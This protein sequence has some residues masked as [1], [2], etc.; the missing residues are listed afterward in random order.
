M[1]L[2]SAARAVTV[3]QAGRRP[4]RRRG[5]RRTRSLQGFRASVTVELAVGILNGKR[6]CRRDRAAVPVPAANHE[7]ESLGPSSSRQGPRRPGGCHCQ[8]AHESAA[9]ATVG[10]R[11][12][13]G[14]TVPRARPGTARRSDSVTGSSVPGPGLHCDGAAAAPAGRGRAPWHWQPSQPG[15]PE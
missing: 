5:V 11:G 6:D 9:S 14:A 10:H 15:S 2:G 7:S 3:T 12:A 13:G 1:C 4:G 8:A